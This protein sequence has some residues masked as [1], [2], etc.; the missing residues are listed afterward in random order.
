VHSLVDNHA[1]LAHSELHRDERAATVTAFVERGL[2][3]HA[4]IASLVT[5]DAGLE[6]SAGSTPPP[7]VDPRH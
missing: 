2:A 7:H 1:R 4:C 6:K 3:F 5:A